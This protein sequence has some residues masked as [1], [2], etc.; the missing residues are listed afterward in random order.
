[1]RLL[2]GSRASRHPTR[3]RLAFSPKRLHHA[4]GDSLGQYYGKMLDGTVIERENG[5]GVGH[6]LSCL[7]PRIRRP[8]PLAS[9]PN[10]LPTGGDPGLK[11]ATTAPADG[12]TGLSHPRGQVIIRHDLEAHG[13]PRLTQP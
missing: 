8:G 10:G 4:R 3:R 11:T 6:G 13:L 5:T 7:L 12:L 9:S 1:M 2:C